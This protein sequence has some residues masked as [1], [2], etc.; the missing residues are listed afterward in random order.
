MWWRGWPGKSGSSGVNWLW[1]PER[2]CSQRTD[3][4][5]GSWEPNSKTK[6]REWEGLSEGDEV[7]SAVTRDIVW[8]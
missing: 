6:G 2:P 4:A 5:A 7:T 1:E 8:R 3:C